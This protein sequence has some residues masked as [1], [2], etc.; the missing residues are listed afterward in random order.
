MQRGHEGRGTLIGT[1]LAKPTA[2]SGTPVPYTDRRVQH[3]RHLHT[4][5]QLTWLHG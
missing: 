2:A 4:W 1:S 5:D 3:N